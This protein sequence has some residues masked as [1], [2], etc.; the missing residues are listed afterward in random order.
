MFF[1][2]ES[3]FVQRDVLPEKLRSQ[4]MNL[5]VPHVAFDPPLLVQKRLHCGRIPHS[6]ISK[7]SLDIKVHGKRKILPF[8]SLKIG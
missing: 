6:R 2:D 1:Q 3:Q 8:P 7:I 4:R 5:T